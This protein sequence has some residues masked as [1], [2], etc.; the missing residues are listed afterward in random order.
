MRLQRGGAVQPTRPAVTDVS[1]P[2]PKRR[3]DN[4]SGV[5]EHGGLLE[6]LLGFL[7]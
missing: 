4:K 6:P 1:H 2:R 7:K 5:S 3:V